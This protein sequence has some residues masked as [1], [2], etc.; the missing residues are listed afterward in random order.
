VTD[1]FTPA[2]RSSVMRAIKGK[3]TKPEMI[4]RSLAHELGYR[5]RLHRRSLPG[6]PDLVFVKQRKVIFVH[7][8][9]WHGHAG[10]R[11]GRLPRS[12]VEY[13]TQKIGRNK[14]RDSRAVRELR[15][16]GWGVMTMWEC[17]LDD[18]ER[19]RGRIKRFLGPRG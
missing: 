6:C 4:V 16:D 12:N 8:C 1:T 11:E 19:I 5:F 10:C 7:G 2:K 13:W 17:Q 3:D 9:F 14:Q 15:K 18:R